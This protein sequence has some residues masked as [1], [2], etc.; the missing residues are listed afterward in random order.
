M[1]PV[2]DDFAAIARRLRE[3]EAEVAKEQEVAQA[4]R[5]A[6]DEP[7]ADPNYMYGDTGA[8]A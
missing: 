2:V 8:C 7:L 1:F 4:R 5:K 3:I 6:E